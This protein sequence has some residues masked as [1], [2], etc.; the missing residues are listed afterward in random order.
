MLP[1]FGQDRLLSIQSTIDARRAA[2][3]PDKS[4]WRKLFSRS[5]SSMVSSGTS[6]QSLKLQGM[7]PEDFVEHQISY[8]SLSYSLDDL[9]DFG[10][11][12][13]HF[14]E[15]GFRA[16]HFKAFEPRHYKRLGIRAKDMLRTSMSIHDLIA[17]NL[18]PQTL[19]SL[20][21]TI[22]QFKSI[23]GDKNTLTALC[24]EQDMALYF[25]HKKM[26]SV[27]IKPKPKVRKS[28]KLVF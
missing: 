5:L 1:N 7:I 26:Q 18:S 16:D 3:K 28:S 10:C 13:E 25:N 23:G 24:N 14:L 9:V 12:Y 22:D 6:L 8:D 27:G 15:M 17:L 2:P 4:M 21:W 11:T 19:H 20:G